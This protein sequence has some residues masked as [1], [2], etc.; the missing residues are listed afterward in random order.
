MKQLRLQAIAEVSQSN[1]ISILISVL[2]ICMRSA[3]TLSIHDESE[4]TDEKTHTH[5]QRENS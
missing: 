4:E 5:T 1:N 3:T 2:A